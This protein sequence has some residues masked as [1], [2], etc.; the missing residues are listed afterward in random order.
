MANPSRSLKAAQD[1][2]RLRSYFA[3]LP[4]AARRRLKEMRA[5]IRATAPN[6][7][8]AFSYGIPAVALDGRVALWYA[9]W[10]AHTSLYP[11][12]AALR[13]AH[14]GALSGLSVSKGTIRFPLAEPLPA[15]LI[16]RLV[17]ARLAE[18]P[19]IRRSAATRVRLP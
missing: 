5:I 2:A 11:M 12:S 10:K 18:I 17:R 14:A 1:R 8:D 7:T 9:A 16:R 15:T 3:A 4:P 13:R 6:A 19:P